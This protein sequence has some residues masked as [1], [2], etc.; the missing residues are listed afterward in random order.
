MV[1]VISTYFDLGF[2]GSFKFENRLIEGL[3]YM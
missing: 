2:L 1:D 3:Q